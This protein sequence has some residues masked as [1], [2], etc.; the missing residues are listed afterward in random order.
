[1][2]SRPR[3]VALVTT[4]TRFG[5]LWRHIE[6]LGAGLQRAEI[7]VTIGLLP[8]ATDLQS[9]SERAGLKW[10]PLHRTLGS[11][12]DVWHVHLSD[13]Y[14]PRAFLALAARGP[15]GP[16]V[17]T[18]H[19][20]RSN[21]SDEQ[22]EPQY[23]RTRYAS[24]C[25]TLF[26]KAEFAL[27]NSVIAVGASSQRFL[28]RR[29]ALPADRVI[30]VY[31]G[32]T[33]PGGCPSP[34]PADGRLRVVAVGNMGRQKGFDILL[35]AARVSAFTWEITFVGSGHDLEALRGIAATLPPGRVRF[36]G[37]VDDP[38]AY[39]LAADVVCMPSR[40]ESFPY[41]ALEA[42]ALCRPV[43]GS[44]VDGLDEII[45]DGE[46][47]ILVAPDRPDALAVALDRLAANPGLAVEFGRAANARVRERFTLDGM[48]QG[49]IGA[50]ASACGAPVS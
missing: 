7:E 32:V 48:V 34:P 47:G 24:E 33:S 29:Y 40:W 22:L 26:K 17:I 42:A 6:D 30:T 31:N 41:A 11:G 36:A 27:A 10:K 23:A 46:T 9:A 37:W 18:E 45:V 14:D 5:G 12:T 50:Y 49:T 1:M 16:S 35:E 28:E 44:L 4:A 19:L 21:A 15:V 13:T 8:A 20:P 2:E 38:T 43:V 25:K 3:S 39:V